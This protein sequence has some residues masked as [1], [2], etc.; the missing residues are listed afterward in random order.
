M[1]CCSFLQKKIAK[2]IYCRATSF[3]KE[4]SF[5]ANDIRLR[6]VNWKSQITEKLLIHQNYFKNEKV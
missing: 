4:M 1:T 3:Y 5:I 6:L 2:I